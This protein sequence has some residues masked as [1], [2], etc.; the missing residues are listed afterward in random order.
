MDECCPVS[1]VVTSTSVKEF[2]VDVACQAPDPGQ[3]LSELLMLS[4][5]EWTCLWHVR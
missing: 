1:C 5:P 2:H 3:V 4:C